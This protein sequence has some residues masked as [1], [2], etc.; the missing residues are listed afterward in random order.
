MNLNKTSLYSS[1]TVPREIGLQGC[2]RRQ[3]WGP[4]AV[5]EWRQGARYSWNT[6][7]GM[8]SPPFFF[9]SFQKLLLLLPQSHENNAE[10]SPS[11]LI[12]SSVLYSTLRLNVLAA[13]PDARHNAD[14]IWQLSCKGCQTKHCAG[15]GVRRRHWPDPYPPPPFLSPHRPPPGRSFLMS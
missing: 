4:R 14:R 13:H 8:I 5:R 3:R 7:I 11:S 9:L 6:A 1:I 2:L 10:V 12:V 15:G